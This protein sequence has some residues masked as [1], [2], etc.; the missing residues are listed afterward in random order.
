MSQA[1][2]L[3]SRPL[4]IQYLFYLLLCTLCNAA[5]HLPIRFLTSLQL[6]HALRPVVPYYPYPARIS[7]ALLVSSCTKLFPILLIVWDYDLPSSS[8]AVSW[9]VMISNV[10][11][12]EILMVCGVFR[13]ASLVAIGAI[14]RAFMTELL[15][16]AVGMRGRGDSGMDV[17]TDGWRRARVL[18]SRG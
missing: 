6:P 18:L 11:A 2:L 17:V 9:A 3:S 12:L 16:G 5:L 10:A 8:S 1:P 7:T 15:L 13:A 14:A 4:V